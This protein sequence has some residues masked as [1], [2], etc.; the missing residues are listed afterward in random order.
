MLGTKCV[1]MDVHTATISVAVLDAAGKLIMD[2]VM[3]TKARTILQFIHG[4]R[5]DLYLMLEEGT[6][7]AWLY[8]LL[9]PCVTSIV[10]CDPRR[11]ALLKEGSESDRIDA[12]KLSSSRV[13]YM[14]V[15]HTDV[16]PV[17]FNCH[18]VMLISPIGWVV[19]R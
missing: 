12:R 1:G 4:L 15:T 11:N 8:D 10:V 5:G 17:S 2:S 19:G 18:M 14:A 13:S 9:K 7:A 16:I 6:W 3:E